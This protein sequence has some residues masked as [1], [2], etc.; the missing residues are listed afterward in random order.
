MAM[1]SGIRQQIGGA[2]QRGSYLRFTGVLAPGERWV[3]DEAG[4][5]VSPARLLSQA[6]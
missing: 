3:M 2:P 5:P 4:R 1:Q 6:L